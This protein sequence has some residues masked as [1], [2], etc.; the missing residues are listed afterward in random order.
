[1][2][3]RWG[4]PAVAVAVAVSGCVA[5]QMSSEGVVSLP[6]ASCAAASEGQAAVKWDQA[7]AIDIEYADDS[8]S[9]SLLELSVGN[10]VILRVTNGSEELNWFRADEFF[11]TTSVNKVVYDGIG[12]DTNCPDSVGIG[13]S[14]TVEFH[15]VPTQEGVYQLTE[16]SLNLPFTSELFVSSA[17][18]YIYV[19]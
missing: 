12:V 13:P 16:G 3:A 14:K 11:P 8:F 19:R 15:L 6:Y 1:M 2:K 7:E 4:L 17:L 5:T 10:P 9:S 18:T